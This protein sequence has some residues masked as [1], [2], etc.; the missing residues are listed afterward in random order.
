M[1]YL[2][3]GPVFI[4]VHMHKPNQASRS[5]MDALMAF[6]PSIQVL[7]GELQA[8]IELHEMLYNVVKVCVYIIFEVISNKLL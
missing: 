4:D 7:K 3:K 1:R 8:A 2:N 6:W 5:F